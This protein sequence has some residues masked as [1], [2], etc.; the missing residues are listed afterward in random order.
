MS[1]NN[2]MPT[3]SVPLDPNAGTFKPP[4]TPQTPPPDRHTQ[5]ATQT[6]TTDVGNLKGYV[7]KE[8]FERMTASMTNILDIYG[9][10]IT[11]LN[12]RLGNLEEGS[13]T[14]KVGPFKKADS[15]VTPELLST[16]VALDSLNIKPDI[17]EFEVIDSAVPDMDRVTSN[18]RDEGISN[19][20]SEDKANR[21]VA[22]YFYMLITLT[23]TSLGLPHV[24]H[25][26]DAM[27]AA[28]GS[29]AKPDAPPVVN[30]SKEA[31][32]SIW[33]PRFIQQLDP[34]NE[35]ILAEIPPQKETRGFT[36][37]FLID[38]FTGICWS[39][40]VYYAPTKY[41][42]VLLPGRCF[43]VLDATYEPYLP[44]KPGQH[45][46]KLTPFFNDKLD[47]A[48][49][50][51]DY[52]NV[53]VFITA[54]KYYPNSENRR[55]PKE[56][57]YFGQYSQTRW[58]DKLDY[59]RQCEL[60]PNNVKEY[61]A[62]K[63][64]EVGRPAWV[65]EQMMK[66]FWPPPVYNGEMPKLGVPTGSAHNDETERE[67]QKWVEDMKKHLEKLRAW[68]KDATVKVTL[69]KKENIMDAF[70]AAD[71]AYPPGLRMWWEYFECVGYDRGFNNMLIRH[72]E[73]LDEKKA[74]QRRF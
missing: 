23:M 59:D 2:G 68:E 14:V 40:G 66:F 32:T 8:L 24:K 74:A 56:Y 70:E 37:E 29:D 36:L 12:T 71:C 27:H 33:Q 21:Y 4:Q 42:E 5:V 44:Q 50:G 65:T 61:W 10:D 35:S 7:T 57:V 67:E 43:W 51:P 52:D 28:T 16:T 48:N 22:T 34:L 58:S 55:K 19:G 72:K 3:R 26:Q 73:D 11:T 45:G 18:H 63:L 54:S 25:Q 31:T 60:V 1:S 17:D 20:V 47:D 13:W 15:D 41:G 30:P 62:Q 6:N 38:L 64:S 69:L 9:K 53:P 46:A 49:R 39:P